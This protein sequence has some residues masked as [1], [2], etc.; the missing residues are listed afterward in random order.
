MSRRV[1]QI[2]YEKV[3]GTVEL[4]VRVSGNPVPEADDITWFFKGQKIISH[5]SRLNISADRTRL[6]IERITTSYYGDYECYVN[7]SAGSS[8]RNFTVEQ[9]CE[10]MKCCYYEYNRIH[11][12]NDYVTMFTYYCYFLLK[13]VCPW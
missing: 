2:I 8:S 5:D 11:C 10:S 3:G 9:A 7:T 6:T 13:C 1:D 12:N 4:V